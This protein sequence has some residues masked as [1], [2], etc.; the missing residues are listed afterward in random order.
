MSFYDLVFCLWIAPVELL[1][2]SLIWYLDPWYLKTIVSP[3]HNSHYVFVFC[4]SYCEEIYHFIF[5]R[6]HYINSNNLFQAVIN[7]FLRS[8]INYTSQLKEYLIVAVC[9]YIVMIV[10]SLMLFQKHF[11]F[12]PKQR[13]NCIKTSLG[14]SHSVD[15]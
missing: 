1:E 13:S 3:K 7:R 12:Q 10:G 15:S 2:T 11:Y 5:G 4:H 9:L 14:N 6:S 8:E